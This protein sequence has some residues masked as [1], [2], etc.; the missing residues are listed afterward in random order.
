MGCGNSTATSAGASQE[1]T[2][3]CMLVYHLKP[4]IWYPAKQRRYEK[5]RRK[6]HDSISKSLLIKIWMG[7]RRRGT[8]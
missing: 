4:S 2:E 8:L 3:G 7:F 6:Y 1:T 5:I